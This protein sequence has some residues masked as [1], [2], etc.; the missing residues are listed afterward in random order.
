MYEF[1]PMKTAPAPIACRSGA[2]TP[3]T[4]CVPP[5]PCARLKKVR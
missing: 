5:T 3:A 4:V 2:D 1:A